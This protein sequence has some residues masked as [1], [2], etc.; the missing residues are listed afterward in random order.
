M[1]KP[2]HAKQLDDLPKPYHTS[3][4]AEIEQQTDRGVAII[5][6]A[7]V[8]IVLREAITARLEN[9]PDIM[10]LLFENRGPL[11][12][13]GARI[14]MGLALSIYGRTAY[15]DLRI[16]KNVRNTFAHAAEAIDFGYP[17][18]AEQC[19]KLWFAQKI[20]YGKRPTPKAPREIY[21]R[22]IELLTD[23]LHD[24]LGRQKQDIALSPFLMMGP[25]VGAGKQTKPT[26]SH[27]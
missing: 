11:Q 18:I 3:V 22:A 20:G 6:G 26:K 5:G 17:G 25:P 1:K 27:S 15:E 10:E 24:N 23:G 13:F 7:Y 21:I 12:D 19:N 9:L 14:Q 8:D 16:I 4:M 2:A